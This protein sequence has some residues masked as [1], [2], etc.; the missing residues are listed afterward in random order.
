MRPDPNGFLGSAFLFNLFATGFKDG[1]SHLVENTIAIIIFRNATS[2]YRSGSRNEFQ[3]TN[4]IVTIKLTAVVDVV[5]VTRH[6]TAHVSGLT[7][8]A[9]RKEAI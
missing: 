7:K 9:R 6:P 4:G 2:K 5:L 1:R 8:C 3:V